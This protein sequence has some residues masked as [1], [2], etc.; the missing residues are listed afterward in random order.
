MNLGAVLK[1]AWNMLWNYRSLWLFGT[2]LA[3]VG[4]KTILPG[5]W[6]VNG[7]HNITETYGEMQ[8]LFRRRRP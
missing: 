8:R 7:Y 2:I 4:V 1:K 5:P 6:L 3:L